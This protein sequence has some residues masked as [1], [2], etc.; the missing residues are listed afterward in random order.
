MWFRN[1]QAY[2]ITSGNIT[3]NSLEEAL[4]Q[5]ALQ[6]CM[7]MEM[8]SRGC[9]RCRGAAHSVAV[10]DSEALAQAG[11]HRVP[12]GVDGERG[13]HGSEDTIAPWL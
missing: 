11:V 3:L 2:R 5:H 6:Q 1:L 13:R 12:R 8:Q 9:P 7:Q 4:S 10:A